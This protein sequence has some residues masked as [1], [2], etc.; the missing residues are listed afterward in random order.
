MGAEGWPPDWEGGDPSRALPADSDVAG[1]I[2]REIARREKARQRRDM[3][4]GIGLILAIVG[5]LLGLM[6]LQVRSAG[7]Y[8]GVPSGTMPSGGR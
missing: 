5:G 6:L 8:P 2:R 3:V 7:K 4:L 1:A